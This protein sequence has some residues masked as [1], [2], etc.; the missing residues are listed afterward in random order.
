MLRTS[1]II[2]FLFTILP[3]MS[4]G[5]SRYELRKMEKIKVQ[6]MAYLNAVFG[7][8]DKDFAVTSVPD[9]WKDKSYVV[10]CKKNYIS[11][12]H[13]KGSN[14]TARRIK[15]LSRN[16]IKLQ[17]SSAVELFSKFFFQEAE[18]LEVNILKP[19]GTKTSIDL[20]Q[21]IKVDTEI[22]RFYADDYH[23]EDYLKIAIPNL[24]V[25]DIIDYI[26]IYDQKLEDDLNIIS[27]L[28]FSYP[29]ATQEIIFDVE[30]SYSFETISINGAPDFTKK[31]NG[32]YNITGSKKSE[33]DRYTIRI[34]NQKISNDERWYFRY[35]SDPTIKVFSKTIIKSRDTAVAKERI[36]KKVRKQFLYNRENDLR[37][38]LQKSVKKDIKKLPKKMNTEETVQF[39]YETIRFYFLDFA[40]DDDGEMKTTPTYNNPTTYPFSRSFSGIN[41]DYFI[42][43]LGGL[44]SDQDIK[45]DIVYLI[46]NFIGTTENVLLFDELELA[47]YVP[48]IDKY[49]W[50]CNNIWEYDHL[51]PSTS[52]A[53]AFHIPFSSGYKSIK[54]NDKILP[55]MGPDDHLSHKK[56]NITFVKDNKLSVNSTKAMTGGYKATNTALLIYN[57]DHFLDDIIEYDDDIEKE[58][59][60]KIKRQRKKSEQPYK[61]WVS[62]NDTEMEIQSYFTQWVNSDF[63]GVDTLYNYELLNSGRQ[64]END[65]L[66]IATEFILEDYIKKAGP[67]LIFS[68]GQ[69]I[70]GQVEL[71]D[72]EIA[73]REHDVNYEYA[74]TLINEFSITL[75]DG[76]QAQGIDKLNYN[77][78]NKNG[79]FISIARQDGDQLYIKTSKIYKKQTVPVSEWSDMVEMLEAAYKFSQAKIVLK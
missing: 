70:G 36:L 59:I 57:S 5:Q 66:K 67:N 32:G 72:E 55:M 61:K 10:I 29:V 50:P 74:R 76:L 8:T 47:L 77:V 79:A 28:S 23:S 58:K 53:H 13:R 39:I 31:E 49:F 25:G 71:S 41:P 38:I 73:S 11:L 1:N 56:A 54:L 26:K 42:Y 40:Y 9:K 52:N 69:L 46:P 65:T 44:L 60:N 34:E 51:P 17:N 6:N 48:A 14:K 63:E 75:P 43:C 64:A 2:L 22:P 3:F 30:D 21:A 24:E 7:E 20:N 62:K 18:Y 45:S 15:G 4:L 27:A 78:D 12:Y 16:R 19:D 35:L 68:I 33:I 37:V